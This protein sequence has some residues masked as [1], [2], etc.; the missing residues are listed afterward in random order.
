[1]QKCSRWD[2]KYYPPPRHEGL[3]MLLLCRHNNN[4]LTSNFPKKSPSI[5]VSRTAFSSSVNG[6][7]ETSAGMSHL[8]PCDVVAFAAFCSTLPKRTATSSSSSIGDTYRAGGSNFNRLDERGGGGE[9]V[10]P[11][12]AE[13][14]AARGV[15]GLLFSGV[16]VCRCRRPPPRLP[17]LAR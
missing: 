14:A 12:N 9:G 6:E 17:S 5:F 7:L 13:A 4:A 16:F 15:V 1:M 2:R 11:A 8:K 3:N 10:T